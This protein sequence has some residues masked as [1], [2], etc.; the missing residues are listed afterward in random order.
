M[1]SRVVSNIDWLSVLLYL[2]FIGFGWVNIYS[3]SFSE[4]PHD[5]FD[6]QQVYAKQGLWILL[7]FVLI[8]IIFSIET[9]FYERFASVIYLASLLSLAGLFIF[10]TKISGATSW[11]DLGVVNFQP[12]EFAKVAT[13]LALA[14]FLSDIQTNFKSAQDQ[15]KAFLIICAPALLIVPQPDVGSAL[16]Y[17]AFFFPLYQEGLSVG[18]FVVGVSAILLFI[19]VLLFGPIWVSVGFVTLTVLFLYLTKNRKTNYIKWVM[20]CLVTIIF[21]FS[22]DYIFHNVFEQRHRD[23]FNI[24]LG[25]KEDPQGIGYNTRQSE[26]AIGSGNWFGKGWMQ[27]TQT[28]GNF[29]PEQHT[30]YIFSTVGEEWGFVGSTFIIVL[31][32]A[33]LLRLLY[34][35]ERQKT[36][37]SRIYGYSVVSILFIHFLVNIGMVIGI[38][39]TIGIPLP[40]FSYGGSSLWGFTI[41][42]FIFIK[43][44]AERMSY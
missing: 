41:L 10:G 11:Y 25:I 26:I 38:L 42:L 19:F 6:F 27:G 28:K 15:L 29:V 8:I 20:V 23:R 44:D 31:F 14:K 16:V 21:V 35:T 37:F 2:F 13:A 4:I 9:K 12:T 36:Q 33:F 17:S 34:L 22:V 7:S 40:F 5:F 1:R 32:V 39:P 30:D 3:A 43:L 24:V 18:Y